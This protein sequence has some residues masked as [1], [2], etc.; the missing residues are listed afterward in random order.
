M[1]SR[2]A[3]STRVALWL[4]TS[5][6]LGY[7]PIAPATWGSAGSLGLYAVMRWWCWWVRAPES[8]VGSTGEISQGSLLLCV[9][10]I[11]ILVV[12]FVG[13]WAARVAAQEFHHPDPSRVVIDEVA[14]QQIALLS[15]APLNWKHAL[16]SFLLFRIFDIWKPFPA[17]Q[18][19]AWPGGWGIMA[20]DWFA[21]LYAALVLALGRVWGI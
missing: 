12:S 18:A 3:L 16:A 20:D 2:P 17:R 7:L 11:V 15:L 4:A 1:N 8:H 21:G 9:Q 14:G 10:L 13:V 6:G 19:E 5:F